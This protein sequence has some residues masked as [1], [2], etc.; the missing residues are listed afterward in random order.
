MNEQARVDEVQEDVYRVRIPIPLI[1][2]DHV[3]IYLLGTGN[4]RFLID[5]GWGS[6]ESYSVLLSALDQ[7]KVEPSSIKNVLITH[8]HYDH[9]GLVKEVKRLTSARISIHQRE[10]KILASMSSYI[11]TAGEWLR[12]AGLGVSEVSE[13][14]NT[15]QTIKFLQ[16]GYYDNVLDGG[17]R[18]SVD[19]GQVEVVWTPG[20][21][22][23]HICLYDSAKKV[24]YSGDHLLPTITSNISYY[25]FLAEYDPLGEYLRSLSA[26]TDRKI[27]VI[28]PSH[29]YT[30]SDI[31]K[32]V[33]EI[34]IHHEKRLAESIDA[35]N[36][37]PKTIRE[38][39]SKISWTA[40]RWEDL[41]PFSKWLALS[42]TVAHLEHLRQI[43]RVQR[44]QNKDIVQ[45][46][47]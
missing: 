8:L 38:V 5:T 12:T 15:I 1:E 19:N 46:S 40:G 24:L 39:A 21:T 17:E 20:H 34:R 11:S 43:G 3:Y 18:F 30:F 29:E 44:Q 47:A 31:P 16:L 37:G 33:S 45:Y 41:P 25:P 35:L 7:L 14:E 4:S 32:R 13:L 9:Y 42:E 2:I 22:P 23:G 36:E 26:L 6:E 27:E 10:A 28:F